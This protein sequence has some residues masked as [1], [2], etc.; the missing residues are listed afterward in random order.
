MPA[1]DTTDV[2]VDTKPVWRSRTLWLNA[3]V[4][5]LAVAELRLGLLQPL[6]DVDVYALIAF[7]LPV[8]NA[9]LRLSTTTPVSYRQQGPGA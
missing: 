9:A 5:A 4:M 6:L 8:A 2:A 3:A 7:V 1:A